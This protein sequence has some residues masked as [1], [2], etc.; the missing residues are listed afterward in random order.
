MPK[1]HKIMRVL[2]KWLENKDAKEELFK[3]LDID[4]KL[5]PEDCFD[6]EGKEIDERLKDKRWSAKHSSILINQVKKAK[7]LYDKDKEKETPITLLEAAL[8]KL[9]HENMVPEAIDINY[10]KYAMD[11]AKKIKETADQLETRFYRFMKDQKKLKDKYSKE[12]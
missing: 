5:P 2:P 1:V 11:L 10:H 7:R 6:D 3:L 8:K 12:H 9:E 4:F